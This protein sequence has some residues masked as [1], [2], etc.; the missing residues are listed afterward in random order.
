MLLDTH[1]VLWWL[2]DSAELTATCTAS[3]NASVNRA[4]RY[5]TWAASARG[6]ASNFFACPI[7]STP[8]PSC[9]ASI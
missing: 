6:S 1:V 8:I 2:D 4:A 7:S 3:L 9:T 5:R